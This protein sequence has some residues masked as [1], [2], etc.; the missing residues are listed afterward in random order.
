MKK[1]QNILIMLSILLICSESIFAIKIK[2]AT[3]APKGTI[4][5]NA[6]DDLNE[7]LKEK[8]QG[9]V[10]FSIYP[11]GVAGDEKD[12]LR[13]IRY[14]RLHSGAFTGA[15]MGI[16]N[17]DSRVLDLPFII[18]DESEVTGLHD[19]L[20]DHLNIG[21]LEKGFRL[22]ALTEVGWGYIFSK[23]PINNNFPDNIKIWSWSGDVLA[24]DY[25][26]LLKIQQVSLSVADVL[27]SLKTGMI[28]SFYSVPLSSIALQW[29]KEIEYILDLPFVH[30]SGAIL[31]SE[32][33]FQ[34][35][36]SDDRNI[37]MNLTKKHI[38]LL[39]I[40]T[41]NDNKKAIKFLKNSGIKF[42]KPEKDLLLEMKKNAESLKITQKG[43]LISEKTLKIIT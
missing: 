35:I 28:D 38:N 17:P 33:L 2:F 39:N 1:T 36:N 20:F 14:K 30:S 16:I 26:K 8:T 43:K 6:M 34:K 21:F 42:I 22:L 5:V 27:T 7:E 31:I 10:S 40:K 25:F 13:K 37:L 18:E 24:R 4:W 11:G 15:G 29:N 3:V 19:K 23:K 41:V 32:D 12:V 9:R